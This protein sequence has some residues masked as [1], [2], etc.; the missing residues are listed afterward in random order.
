LLNANWHWSNFLLDPIRIID[1]D[2]NGIVQLN[3]E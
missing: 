2:P 3:Q 1:Y